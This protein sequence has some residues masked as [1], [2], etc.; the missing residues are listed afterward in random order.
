MI[1]YIIACWRQP[2]HLTSL[3]TVSQSSGGYQPNEL[4]DSRSHHPPTWSNYRLLPQLT[5]NTTRFTGL[6]KTQRNSWRQLYR[7]LFQAVF[8]FSNYFI[9][10]QFF[11]G[12]GFHPKSTGRTMSH[13]FPCGSFWEQEFGTALIQD[14]KVLEGWSAIMPSF[15]D[16]K[17]VAVRLPG[18]KK[19]ARTEDGSKNHIK[20]DMWHQYIDIYIYICIYL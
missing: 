11:A 7:I 6:Q 5:P 10:Q 2:L 16:G 13:C 19:D 1:G 8:K 4:L 17:D 9:S 14:S 3:P 18:P 15:N 12:C 20:F